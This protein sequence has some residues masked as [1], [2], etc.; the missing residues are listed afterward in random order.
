MNGIEPSANALPPQPAKE[1]AELVRVVSKLL[2]L[3]PPNPRHEISFPEVVAACNFYQLEDIES[4]VDSIIEIIGEI[5]LG[6]KVQQ[7]K[8]EFVQ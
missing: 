4:S 6:A 7:E 8:Q 5:N 1:D 3:H 2:K